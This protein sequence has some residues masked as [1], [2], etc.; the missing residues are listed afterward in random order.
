MTDAHNGFRVMN[1]KAAKKI[2]IVCDRMAH[3]SEIIEEIHRKK[4]AYKEIPVIIN[5]NEYT[6][7]HGHGSFVG[8]IKVGF[9]INSKL[10]ENNFKEFYNKN[11]KLILIFGNEKFGLTQNLRDKLDYSF[12]LTKETKKPLRASHALSYIMGLID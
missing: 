11:K 1:R 6:L 9:S 8:G 4:L 7:Q 12:R 3:A 2:E 5:Y 10:N